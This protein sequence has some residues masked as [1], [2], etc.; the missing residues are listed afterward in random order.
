[1]IKN[2]LLQHIHERNQLVSQNY[3][4]RLS[5]E[6][7]SNLLETKLIKIITGPRRSGKSVCGLLLLKD[8]NFAYINFDDDILLKNYDEDAVIEAIHQVY[9]G[10]EYI[11]F[12]EIQNVNNWE[13]LVNKLYRRNYNLVLTGSNAKLLSKELATSLTG[14]YISIEILPFS[15]EEYY[16]IKLNREIDYQNLLPAQKGELSALAFTYLNE[17]GFPE[18]IENP[19][20]QKT[21]LSTLFD[22]IIYKDIVRR[23]N[24]RNTNQINDL[25]IYL[26]TNYT[27]LYTYNSL[28]NELNFNSVTSVQKYTKYLEEPYLFISLSKFSYKLSLQKKSAKKI[29][30]IDNGFIMARS[31]EFSPNYGRLLENLIF[32]ELL[33]KGYKPDLGLFYYQTKNNLEIDFLIRKDIEIKALIQVAYDI[34]DQKTFKREINALLVASKELSVTNLVLITW[35]L[36]QNFTENN[37]NINI[38]PF[39][40]FALNTFL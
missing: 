10:F 24:V 23:F 39:W 28:C 11:F 34:S 18:C 27:N 31:F 29:Y 26:L 25:A 13:I 20:I 30:I 21:Y 37:L 32:I 4:E 9:N 5:S 2:I 8:T 17:G 1:M 3:I 33:R 16:R 38:I 19:N 22:S 40:K 7:K 15:F 35:D 6:Q 36:E 14:R 12:D